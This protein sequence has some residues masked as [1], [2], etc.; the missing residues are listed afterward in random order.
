MSNLVYIL[1]NSLG[2]LSQSFKFLSYLVFEIL[3]FKWTL[4]D[5]FFQNVLKYYLNL[6]KNL[7]FG[8]R[9]SNLARS[10]HRSWR[11]SSG[12]NKAVALTGFE[13]LLFLLDS[14]LIEHRFLPKESKN[15]KFCQKKDLKPKYIIQVSIWQLE[16]L[17]FK[18]LPS[19]VWN[20]YFR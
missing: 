19:R 17:C 10:K 15:L 4:L 9:D 12:K 18:H 11:N 20:W 3:S 6:F 8:A 13:I 2:S 16:K 1:I 14:Y 5:N 7:L